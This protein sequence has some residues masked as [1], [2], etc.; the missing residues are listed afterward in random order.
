M[1]KYFAISEEWPEGDVS[2]ML[3]GDSP[4]V[5]PAEGPL[6][7][8]IL[9]LAQVHVRKSHPGHSSEIARCLKSDWGKIIVC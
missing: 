1:F 3:L 2:D 5:E 7:G 6:S 9:G 4:K 8:S